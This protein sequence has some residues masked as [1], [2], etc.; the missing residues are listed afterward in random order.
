MNEEESI[1]FWDE[2]AEGY[3]GQFAELREEHDRGVERLIRLANLNREDVVLDLGTGTGAVALA[4][5]PQ[6]REV[7]GVDPS[8]KMLEVARKK[9]HESHLSNVEFRMG[10]FTNPNIHEKVDMILSN[11]AF[12]VIA[13]DAKR[14]AIGIMYDTLRERGRVILGDEMVCYDREEIRKKAE[15]MFCYL[16][17][18]EYEEEIKS[19]FWERQPDVYDLK[20][21]FDL[22]LHSY[23]HSLDNPQF[24]PIPYYPC[25]V[26]D[27]AGYFAQSGFEVRE[28]ERLSPY[29][30]VIYA[31]R[32]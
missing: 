13:D 29:Y 6:V 1:R 31:Q 7:I 10:S 17:V 21:L 12:H 3:D 14:H 11:D 15:E 2:I 26:D 16:E 24:M 25:K 28:V 30:G 22:L 4:I 5:A 23:F 27:L 20:K 32:K 18:K 9:A 8:Q 19:V